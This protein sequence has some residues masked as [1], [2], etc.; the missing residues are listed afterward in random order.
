MSITASAQFTIYK[1][2]QEPVVTSQ[3]SNTIPIISFP[4][5]L[6]ERMRNQAVAQAIARE[7]QARAMEIVSSDII[8]ADGYNFISETYSP[9]KVK[10]I[11]RRNGQVELHCLGIKK[12]GNWSTCEKE[13]A[14]LEAMYN[15]ATEKSAKDMI[16][17]LMEYGNYLLII[18]PKTEVYIIK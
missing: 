2:I 9:L 18:N 6:E 4:D 17:E 5:P 8:T 14:S 15:K 13:I 11:R 16:L 1:P 10:I 3:R 7:A 12:N